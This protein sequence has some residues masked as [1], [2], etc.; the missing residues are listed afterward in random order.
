MHRV[1]QADFLT[2]KIRILDQGVYPPPILLKLFPPPKPEPQQVLEVN[3]PHIIVM[4]LLADQIN[5]NV[6]L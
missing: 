3:N 5:H 1:R 4:N 2:D 6:G